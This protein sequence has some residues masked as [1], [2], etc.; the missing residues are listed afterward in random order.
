MACYL[1]VLALA[2]TGLPA[3]P[4]II[5]SVGCAFVAFSLKQKKQVQQVVQQQEE[6]RERDKRPEPKPEDRLKVH[7]LKLELGVGLLRLTDVAAGGDLLDRVTRIRH[8]IAQEMGIILP[9]VTICDNIRLAQRDYQFK[10]RDV[11]VAWGDVHPDGLLAIN[12][13]ATTGEVHG[14][15]A[16]EP[17][18]QRPG[19]WI[20]PGQKERAELLGYN[21]VEPTAVIITHL[22]EIVREHSPQILSRQQVHQLIDNLR[23][24]SPSVVEELI[25]DI[26]KASQVHQVLN[27]LLRERVPIRDLESNSRNTWRLCDSHHRLRDFD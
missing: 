14:I 26:L 12:T 6:V 10:I 16:I 7:P 20:D 23:E 11:P 8:Q 17:A 4:M 25:P 18:Y 9:S 3:T 22:M 15:D 24:G 1:L 5:L 27:N 19:K 2:F 13:G 21:V